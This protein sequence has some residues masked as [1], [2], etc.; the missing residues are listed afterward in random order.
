MAGIAL[1]AAL[2]NLLLTSEL[3]ARAACLSAICPTGDKSVTTS[4]TLGVEEVVTPKF[5]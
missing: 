5:S 1:E 2:A 3:R 4:V